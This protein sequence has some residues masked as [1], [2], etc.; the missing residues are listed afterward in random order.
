VVQP[1]LVIEPRVPLSRE[2]VLR[3]AVELADRGGI[4]AVSMRRLGQELGVE[5]MAPYRHV[6]SKDEIVDGIVEVVVGE[7]AIPRPGPDWKASMRALALSARQ[8]MLRHP[9][10]PAV[11]VARTTVGPALLAYLDS[12]MAI[13][14]EAGFSIEMAHHA[15]H[16]MGSR[17]L[18]FT[19]DP[20]DD[21]TESRPDP[22]VAE[23]QARALAASFPHLG[24]LA[25]AVTHDGGLGGCDDDV[26][27]AFGLDL[28][29]DGLE[30]HRSGSGAA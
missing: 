5:A 7:I 8:V 4:E 30:R 3:T 22:A 15:L 13:L 19:Q 6:R 9:W 18:G 2:R 10:A 11:I 23:R 12:V 1:D 17:V 29:L 27:F 25:M 14:L 28:I 21:S 24:Q 16:V 20:F 26:E